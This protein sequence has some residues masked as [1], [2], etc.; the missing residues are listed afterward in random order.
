MT[1]SAKWRTVFDIRAK[2]EELIRL[3]VETNHEKF[4]EN[5]ERAREV[6]SEIKTLK[7]GI[8]TWEGLVS[9][10]GALADLYLVAGEEGTPAGGFEGELAELERRF[11]RARRM[12]FMSGP[13]DKSGAIVSFYAGAG[14]QD[15]EDWARI[16]FRMYTRFAERKG[17]GVSVLHKH[18]NDH[19]DIKNATIKI[20]GSYAYGQLR[21]EMGVHR[22]VRISPFSS[23][24]LRHTSFAYVEVLPNLPKT[25]DIEIREDDVEISFARSSGPGGQNVNK[26]STAVRLVHKPTGIAVHADS[27]R[28][29]LANREAAL[30]ILRAK[31]F[32]LREESRKRELAGLKGEIP[33]KIEWGSQ[34][35]SY[36]VHPYQMVKDHRTGAESSNVDAVLDGDLDLFIEHDLLR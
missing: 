24:K 3:E 13:Y 23:K 33:V 25:A 20:E 34:I 30:S 36:V 18:E 26:R 35:R 16:L 9:D 22:L 29:Q 7:D 31:L 27:E 11:E 17:W 2:K 32:T 8:S 28:S 4:W 19:G 6:A 21:G 15:A 12:A 10:I 1:R 14:G 5:H